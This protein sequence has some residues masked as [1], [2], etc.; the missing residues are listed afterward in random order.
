MHFPT[1]LSFF[2]P[3]LPTIHAAPHVQRDIEYDNAA[4]PPHPT[5]PHLADSVGVRPSLPFSFRHTP[6]LTHSLDVHLLRP[7][8]PWRMLVHHLAPQQ[9]TLV[10]LRPAQY[11]SNINRT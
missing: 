1:F 3:F 8:L 4:L 5:L 11:Y 7:R 10:W 2:A 6:Q 9:R